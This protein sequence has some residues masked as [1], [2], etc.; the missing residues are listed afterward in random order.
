MKGRIGHNNSSAAI[1]T[2]DLVV[3]SRRWVSCDRARPVSNFLVR[4]MHRNIYINTTEGA[5]K[6]GNPGPPGAYRVDIAP[7]VPK[8]LEIENGI[9][10]L[11]E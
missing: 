11:L 9:H 10:E 8:P 7:T 5:A 1:F 2:L 6:P 4:N 3:E